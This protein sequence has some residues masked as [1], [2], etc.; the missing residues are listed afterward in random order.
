MAR[1]TRRP[2]KRVFLNL[3]MVLVIIGCLG[4]GAALGL[5]AG[6]LQTIPS[7]E[8]LTYRPNLA[9]VVYDRH[10][11]VICRFMVEN[12]TM[13]PLSQIPKHLQDAIVA[14]EDQHSGRTRASIQSGY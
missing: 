5:L 4:F 9:T 6:T 10:G 12:R 3:L 7:P 14:F 11:E 13:V 2:A 8:A 1:T